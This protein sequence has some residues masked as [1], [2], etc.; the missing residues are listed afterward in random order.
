MSITDQL[1]TFIVNELG[2]RGGEIADDYPLIEN[3]VIDSLG[4]FQLVGYLETDY[5]VTIDD[6]DL[7]PDKFATLASI[8]ELVEGAKSEQSAQPGR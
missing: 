4:I 3:H 5:G 7:T 2:W 8:A 1:R 6:G